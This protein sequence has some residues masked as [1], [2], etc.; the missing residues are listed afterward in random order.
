MVEGGV[1]VANVI[2]RD[3]WSTD[4]K[5]GE[6]RSRAVYQVRWREGRR[7]RSQQFERRA[8]AELFCA[9]AKV[10]LAQGLPAIPE[11]RD[12]LTAEEAIA[13]HLDHREAHGSPESARVY[14]STFSQFAEWVTRGGS[15]RFEMTEMTPMI[16]EEWIAELARGGQV[17]KNVR[18]QYARRVLGMWRWIAQR[19]PDRCAP[20][21]AVTL[22]RTE[23]REQPAP[24]WVEMD[25]AIAAARA[26]AGWR[27][28]GSVQDREWLV[29]ALT[30]L[31][32]TGL[33]I[34]QVW[35][36]RWADLD[37]E[38]GTLHARAEFDRGRRGRIVPISPH[39]HRYLLSTRPTGG[40]LIERACVP[41]SKWINRCWRAAEVRPS[42]TGWHAFRRGVETGL[43]A[44]GVD[45]IRIRKLIGHTMGVD[46]AYLSAAGLDLREA[47][48]RIP[49]I[50]ERS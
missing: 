6:R 46:D 33:R 23:Q 21:V 50:G 30:I 48:S 16:V 20:F 38:Q 43:A 27:R 22:Q 35:Q 47:V 8:D 39:L 4:R 32:F 13:R 7:Q 31:R 40:R 49:A 42:I 45:L 44:E 14:L 37:L 10:R 3:R 29:R 11:R 41:E 1:S 12:P 15:R 5:T 28:V 18:L 24:S 19:Y 34:G 25:R 9:Q 36:L 17:S 2:K 26:G